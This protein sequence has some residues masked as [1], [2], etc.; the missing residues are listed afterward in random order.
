MY[1]S[2][3]G[4]PCPLCSSA[5]G[6]LPPELAGQKTCPEC[7]RALPQAPQVPGS[8]PVLDEIDALIAQLDE[9]ARRSP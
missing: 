6:E 9:S 7:G 2:R 5:E 8:Q 1:Y 3:T 4:A